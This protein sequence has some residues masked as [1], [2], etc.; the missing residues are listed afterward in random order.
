MQAEAD[1]SPGRW[2][3]G[4]WLCEVSSTRGRS[5]HTNPGC[6]SRPRLLAPAHAAGLNFNKLSLPVTS[7]RRG[8]KGD[9]LLFSRRKPSRR[10]SHPRVNTGFRS[11][12]GAQGRRS[13]VKGVAVLLAGSPGGGEGSQAR[14][15][16]EG[17]KDAGSRCTH[18]G[19][20]RRLRLRPG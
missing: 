17:A 14:A 2:R 20:S 18:P 6:L 12:W 16:A 1:S 9:S 8:Q 13:G 5:Q 7:P 19:S 3:K 10:R 4:H 15:L 11:V